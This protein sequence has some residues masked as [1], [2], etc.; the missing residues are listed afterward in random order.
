MY[1][2]FRRLFAVLDRW[3]W[4]YIIAGLLMITGIAI[5][6]LEPRVMQ[7]AV[8][9]IITY[10]GSNGS[11]GQFGDD[12][13]SQFFRW[14][15]P[16]VTA[17]NSGQL[18]AL[19]GGF[20]VLIAA[21]RSGLILVSSLLRADATEK[22]IKHLRDRLFA[23]VQRLPMSYFTIM[24]KG[25]LIQRSTWDIH[26]VRGFIHNHIVEVMSTLAL[27][28][29]SFAMMVMIDRE[30]AL[31]AVALSPLIVVT[32]YLF[33]ERERAVW[34]QR[35]ETADELDTV[36][37]ETLNGIRTVQAFA[38]ENYE[39]RKFAARNHRKLT[40]DL[41]H[42]R[43]HTFFWP[44]SNFLVNCQTTLTVV[45]GGYFAATGKITVGELIGFY[46]YSTMLSWP[47]RQ[48]GQILSRIGVATVA[49]GRIHEVLDTPQEV[50]SGVKSD[51]RLR[52]E[53]EFR[54]VCFRYDKASRENVLHR[55]SFKIRSG[56]K[57]AL[58]GPTGAGKS[59]IVNLL[60][61]LYPPDSGQVLVDGREV[62]EYSPRYLRRKIGF[63]LQDAFLF[64][65]TVR[66]NI[67]YA[68]PNA[69]MDAIEESAR[70]AR[71]DQLER[72]LPQG[73]DTLL[74]EKGVTLS[75]GQKQRVA[76]A[77]TL[78]TGPDILV[79]DD[80]TSAVDGETEQAIF[81][82]LSEMLEQK[83]TIIIS[84]RVTSIQQADRVLVIHDGR[85][86][87]EGTREDLAQRPGYY[88]DIHLLQTALEA[89]I[90]RDA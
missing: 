20:F 75:G 45:A 12:R 17:Q 67:A 76:L 24:P 87:Q 48:F 80:V 58:V 82:A 30:Y 38:N 13:I 78:L 56:E 28:G 90:L 21:W 34:K 44:A 39:I 33:F 73:Y 27:F 16:E 83:T 43:L 37:Q 62:A 8:D 42:L 5:R 60:V 79:L 86:V 84:H 4:R 61:G 70:L 68:V 52:G 85:I 26:T 89:E 25:D 36:V 63:V 51:T 15:L 32:S 6:S 65:T 74:G 81:A 49:I 69:K 40:V 35:Q 2:N 77:R 46:A 57:V 19:L 71:A 29:F 72:V 64:S 47:M 22:A 59:T 50:Q 3:K 7:I 9:N 54:N 10:P 31:V 14:M 53:I 66:R 23:H 41:R 18:L 11:D 88:R 1:Q 55:I